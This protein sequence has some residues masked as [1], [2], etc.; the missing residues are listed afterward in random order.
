MPIEKVEYYYVH[1][2]RCGEPFCYDGQEAIMD[3]LTETAED[4]VVAA[5]WKIER[6]FEIDF[7]TATCPTCQK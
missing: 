1:C 4:K 5:G 6:E 2:D 7:S 3:G